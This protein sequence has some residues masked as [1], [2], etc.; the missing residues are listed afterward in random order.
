[1]ALVNSLLW[2]RAPHPEHEAEQEDETYLVPEDGRF[3]LCRGLLK[4]RVILDGARWLSPCQVPKSLPVM[5]RCGVRARTTAGCGADASVVTPNRQEGP[6][7]H[8]GRFKTGG[9]FF[10]LGLEE[11]CRP[12]V[13][14]RSEKAGSR[15][16]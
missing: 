3:L 11:M 1:M 13:E 4:K 16:V 14:P 2:H 6:K 12:D 5:P 15:V 10:D 7:N 8:P 9:S